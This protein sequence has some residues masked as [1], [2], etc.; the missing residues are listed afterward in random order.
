MTRSDLDH[1]IQSS[2]DG[3]LSEAECLEL[4]AV[5]K[6]DP[7]ARALYY[8]YAGLQQSL[9]FRISGFS[10]IDVARGFADIRLRIQNRRTKRVSMIA[11]AAVIVAALVAMQLIFVS[12]PP[13]I[14]TYEVAPGSVFTIEGVDSGE[15][16]TEGLSEESVVKLTQGSFELV[17][18][19]GTRGVVVA[20]AKFQLRDEKEL[21]L[22]YGTVWVRV[23]DEG[24]GFRVKTPE[25]LVTDL[26]TKFGVRSLQNA[27]DEV[28]VF[29]GSVEVS[30]PSGTKE[31]LVGGEARL[32]IS[33]KRLL[34][35]PVAPGH[36]LTELP[37]NQVHFVNGNFE[38]GTRPDD[39]NFGSK[40]T[41][42]LLPGWSFGRDIAVTFN[43]SSGKL[44]H[45]YYNDTIV[46]STADVQVGF[47][48]GPY[49][50]TVG[51][52]DDSIWQT[53]TTVPG[54]QYEVSFEMGGFFS[55]QG[56]LRITATIYNG[57]ATSGSALAQTSASRS[58]K[59]PADNGYNK[60]TQFTFTAQSG[61][62]TLA[63]TETSPNSKVSAP[64][65]DNVSVKKVGK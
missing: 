54:Q 46:S 51:T 53:F 22:S 60:P 52:P 63:L 18:R 56:N 5:L 25:F 45:G 1:A 28:H 10:P 6:S 61:L 40:A 14:A 2:F 44:G 35:I 4:R 32:R 43:S 62:T 47:H 31:T 16:T 20:P 59:G 23:S 48:N 15:G 37:T 3:T 8:E 34:S 26:G 57:S 9:V 49:S 64:A 12:D 29:S 58:G 21:D 7:A 36:F 38:E 17:L 42:A 39:A 11:A 27:A 33:S 24:K 19:D 50:Y 30:T 55:S 13:V 41:S 65:I